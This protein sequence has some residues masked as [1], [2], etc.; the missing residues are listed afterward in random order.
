M[1]DAT[2]RRSAATRRQLWRL[3]S[4]AVTLGVLAGCGGQ[5][6]R[7]QVAA[8]AQAYNRAFVA[9]NGRTVCALM[10][11]SLRH[12]FGGS[13]GRGEQTSCAELISFAAAVRKPDYAPHLIITAVHISGSRASVTFRGKAGVGTLPFSRAAGRWRVAGPVHYSSRNWLQADYRVSHAGDLSA[14]EVASIVDSRADTIIG[15]PVQ[16]LAIGP[17]E[18]RLAVTEPARLADLAPVTRR[19]EGRLSFY[20]WE[21]NA[22]T[23]AGTPVGDGLGKRD[24]A[25]MLISQ[26]SGAE[27]PGATGGLT[28]KNALKLAAAQHPAAGVTLSQ[29][30]VHGVP[31][32]WTVVAGQPPSRAD[33]VAGADP[34]A[35]Y[36]VLRDHPALTRTAITDAYSTFDAG[37]R[38]AIGIRF[39]PEG[40]RAFQSLS[41]DVARRGAMLST[42][43]R[44]LNQHLAAVLDGKLLSVIFVNYHVYG[45]GIPANEATDISGGF[46]PV[47]AYRFANEI[48]AEPL[49]ADLQLIR[50]TT[51]S[52]RVPPGSD[53]PAGGTTGSRQTAGSPIN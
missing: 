20:D 29:P 46:T 4:V 28:L 48:S 40:A 14:S 45:L 22:L 19:D 10:T 33:V 52:R 35:R 9:A 7:D 50:A 31:R 36:F 18:V 53:L 1:A 17:D 16:A 6:G 41:A 15:A 2:M 47:A 32:G 42:P 21:A 23:P 26:G 37:G 39:T 12:E 24:D 34:D 38:P 27:A 3:A 8:V 11:S 30:T 51:V 25:A 13:G 44:A 43:G 5:S 49:P